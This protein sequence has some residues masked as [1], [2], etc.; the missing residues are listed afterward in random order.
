[1]LTET[2]DY[3]LKFLEICFLSEWIKTVSTLLGFGR[4]SVKSCDSL[5]LPFVFCWEEG[6]GKQQGQTANVRR[7]RIKERHRVKHLGFEFI[8]MKESVVVSLFSPH[9]S[10]T[11]KL[12]LKMLNFASFGWYERQ[13]LFFSIFLPL[14]FLPEPIVTSCLLQYV[15]LYICIIPSFKQ[16]LLKTGVSFWQ[17]K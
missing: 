2:R 17:I 13:L 3:F 14:P 15:A 12:R 16:H 11:C 1:M 5:G 6:E 4:Q 7:K 9:S 8:S 10:T